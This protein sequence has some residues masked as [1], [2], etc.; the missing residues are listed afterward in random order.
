MF[1][2]EILS[3]SWINEYGYDPT[4]LCFHGDIK[5]YIGDEI[6]ECCC[7]ISAMGLRLL[8]TLTEQHTIT[9]AEQQMLPM[10]WTLYGS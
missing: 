8:K 4:N 1:R 5:V 6:F 2:I 7:T 9:N 10:L 3:K